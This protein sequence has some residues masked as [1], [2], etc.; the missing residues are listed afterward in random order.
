MNNPNSP[1]LIYREIDGLLYPNL[2]L[3]TETQP[4]GKY[5]RITMNYLRDH[6]PQRFQILLMQ[7][8]LM[9]TIQKV[10]Q[11]ALER[12]EQLT[13]QLLRVRPMP[14]TDDTLKRTQHLNQIKSMAEE[15]VLNDTIL[16]PR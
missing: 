6:H 13:D 1:N 16:K 12:M 5:G 10:E 2:N 8:T 7:G 15:L 3:T 11:E 14:Q 4:L 9:E